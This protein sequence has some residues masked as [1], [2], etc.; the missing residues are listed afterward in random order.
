MFDAGNRKRPMGHP[1]LGV[2]FLRSS[3]SVRAENLVLRRQL[4]QYI[5]RGIKPKRADHAA[6]V[7]LALLTRFFDWRDSVV[8]VCLLYDG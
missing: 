1:E 2:L 8:N 5:E 7:G 3:P 4:A 6:R